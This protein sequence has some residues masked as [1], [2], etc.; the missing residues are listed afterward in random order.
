MAQR[1]NHAIRE[2]DSYIEET[3]PGQRLWHDVRANHFR[4]SILT[5]LLPPWQYSCDESKTSYN[6]SR[7]IPASDQI[8]FDTALR[9][10]HKVA[11]HEQACH[12]RAIAADRRAMREACGQGVQ[13]GM[14]AA[15][16]VHAKIAAVQKVA[17]RRA[18]SEC[19]MLRRDF[20]RIDEAMRSARRDPLN[21]GVIHQDGLTP[22]EALAIGQQNNY[23]TKRA[24]AF[25]VGF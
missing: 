7:E 14:D 12:P 25:D 16:K 8:F 22:S 23:G 3:Y 1:S 11:A 2:R 17:S 15:A 4:H 10:Q 9:T 20:D 24:V 21:F 5:R 19:M 6:P 13:A 18:E